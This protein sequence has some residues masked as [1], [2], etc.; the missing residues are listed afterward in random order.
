[1]SRGL[2]IV[3]VLVNRLNVCVFSMQSYTTSKGAAYFPSLMEF[4]I[5][6]GIV[7]LGVFLFKLAARHLPLFA[8]A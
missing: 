3:G 6:L 8:K 4:L 7:A 5:T 1:M 2:V